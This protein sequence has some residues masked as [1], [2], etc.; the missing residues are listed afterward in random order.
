MRRRDFITLVGGTVTCWP[1]L[2]RAQQPEMPVIGFLGSAAPGPYAPYLVAIRRGLDEAGFVENRNVR[3]EYRWAEGRYERLPALAAELVSR[4]VAVIMTSGGAPAASAAKSAT[5]TIPIVFHMG[6]D[7]VSLGIVASLNRPGGNITGVSFLTGLSGSKRLELLHKLVPAAHSVGLLVNPD[8]ASV[9][10]PV[11]KDLKAAA[12]TLGL[13]LPIIEARNELD[14]DAAFPAFVQ[15]GAGALV[16]GA[17]QLFRVQF[18]QIIALAARHS[19]PAIYNTRDFADAG[20]LMSY[21][22]SIVDAYRLEGTY[23]GRVLKGEKPADLPV[24]QSTKFE[25]VINLKTATILGLKVPPTLLAL[26][27]EVIE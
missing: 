25:L 26:A 8:N 12:A 3:I 14:I 22:A 5:S 4:Q 9:T 21:G 1:L 20:G 15:R 10:E 6:A 11:T 19:L 13:G 17:D 27:D 16:V 7:P 23:V 24:M 2:A 18:Q